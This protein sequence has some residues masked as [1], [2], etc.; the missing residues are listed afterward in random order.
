MFYHFI[1]ELRNAHADWSFLNIFQ[2][3]TVRS[4]LAIVTS[5]L[6]AMLIGDLVI[7]GLRK[8][9]IAQYIREEGPASHQ[10]KTGTPTM[11]GVIIVICIL[12][13]MIFWGGMNRYTLWVTFTFVGMGVIGFIDDYLKLS[14]RHNTGLTARAKFLSQVLVALAVVL[15]MYFNR[16]GFPYLTSLYMPFLD[17]P[18]IQD[19]GIWFVP[20]GVIV[21]VGFTNA[22]NISDGLDGLAS[23]LVVLA[24][25]AFAVICYVS[26]HIKFA[27]YLNIPY[28]RGAGEITVFLM[29]LVGAGIGF[30]WFN[31]YPARVF[32]GD[33]GALSLGGAL[34]VISLVTKKELLL[35]IIGGV[36]VLEILSVVIQV[37]SYKLFKRRVFKMSPLHHHFELQGWSEPQV[38]IRF[39]IIG[40]IFTVIGLSVLKIK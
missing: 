10:I 20:F 34:G 18:F 30:L 8:L 40:I 3:I 29:A 35:V 27:D 7:R 19:L 13:S 31:A 36:F 17:R 4:A 38:V 23:G 2:Y 26:G 37:F 9:K 11:G 39:W 28:L 14:K 1:F 16:G 25:A 21:I 6:V 22:I 5:F 15:F 33:V 12:V 32:M 24:A